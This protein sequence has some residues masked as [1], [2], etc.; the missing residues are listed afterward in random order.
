MGVSWA[1]IM[2]SLRDKFPA[3]PFTSGATSNDSCTSDGRELTWNQVKCILATFIFQNNVIKIIT[4]YVSR[5]SENNSFR[6][7]NCVFSVK[8][9]DILC[10][11]RDQ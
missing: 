11:G 8:M 5:K 7:A 9:D 2:L 10:D 3:S 4:V 6:N 1:K